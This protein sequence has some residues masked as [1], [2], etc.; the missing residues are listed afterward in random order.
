[1]LAELSPTQTAWVMVLLTFLMVVIA[2]WA[3]D[4]TR[5]GLGSLDAFRPA[6]RLVGRGQ[7]GARRE[8]GGAR[9][10]Q[11]LGV[12]AGGLAGWQAGYNLQDMGAC[13]MRPSLLSLP[14]SL[15]STHISELLSA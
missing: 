1:M 3:G 2:S 14:L 12:R 15:S 9:L 6:G 7:A 8:L 11:G 10:P 5:R 4:A 13:Q